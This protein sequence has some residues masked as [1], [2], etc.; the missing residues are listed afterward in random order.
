MVQVPWPVTSAPGDE[1]S[2]GAGRLIN[3]FAERRG[4]EQSV[5]WRRVP[6][7]TVFGRV[8]SVGAAAG[9]AHLLGVSSVIE[10]AGAAAGS[11]TAPGVLTLVVYRDTD[12]DAIGGAGASGV[13]TT[14]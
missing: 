14:A 9:S 3:V 1:P 4:D 12:G 5:V 2:E 13:G 8:P 7:A 11:A 10:A 6:G